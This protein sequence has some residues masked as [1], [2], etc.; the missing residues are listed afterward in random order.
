MANR[1]NRSAAEPG[2][3]FEAAALAIQDI[4][5]LE[6]SLLLEVDGF[7]EGGDLAVD[8]V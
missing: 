4:G 6:R 1:F 2:Q 5:L 3:S 8:P 7:V